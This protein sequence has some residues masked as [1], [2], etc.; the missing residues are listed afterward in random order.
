MK[1]ITL[2]ADEGLIQ[3]ARQKASAQHRSLN[4]EFRSWLSIYVADSAADGGYQSA[5]SKLSHIDAGRAF[6]RDE[7]NER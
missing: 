6:T 3:A 7:A 1:N 4:D 2:S 5:M